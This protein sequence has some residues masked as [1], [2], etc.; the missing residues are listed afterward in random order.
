MVALN[1]LNVMDPNAFGDLK[2]LAREGNSQQG[3]RATAEQFEAMF[4]QM[5]LKAMRDATPQ[6]GLF[7]SDQ[8]RMF[9][10]L[11][12]QQMAM[13]MAQGRGV[14][15][16]DV[17]FRQ[18]GGEDPG[19]RAMPHAGADGRRA[20]DLANVPR[21]AAISAVSR[22]LAENAAEQ[23]ASLAGRPGF[24]VQDPAL[25]LLTR[26][27]VATGGSVGGAV[28]ARAQGTVVARAEDAQH[29]S[30]PE[31]VKD[32]VS[33]VWSHA[34]DAGQALG[35][36]A[37]FMVAQAA[38]ETGWGRA[39]LRRPDGS[40]SYNLFNIK[41]GR[42]WTGP[43]VEM[44]VTEYANGRAY[45]ENARFRAYG[46]Y[47]EAFRDYVGLMR[48]SARYAGVIGQRDAAAFAQGLQD[49]GYATDPHYADKL[50]RIIGGPTLRA[51]LEG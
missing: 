46:S 8:T 20:F 40:P 19:A 3:L 31:R 35:V 42:N 50:T 36:P 37:Q 7:D 29:R 51:A 1:Q 41:A 49:A 17:I 43:V 28:D 2:R 21:R 5:A 24:G 11:Q 16:A 30:I 12:D 22:R 10:S 47:D 15:L 32:F 6:N 25:A 18:L 44:P 48:D 39:E 14:G 27:P 9:Q 45:T 13:H 33:R 4:L 26:S 23:A 34:R 38:L